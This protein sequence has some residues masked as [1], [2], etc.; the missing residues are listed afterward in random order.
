LKCLSAALL[1]TSAS[2]AAA[3]QG[4]TN[5]LAS[6]TAHPSYSKEDVAFMTGMIAHHA[7][8]LLMAGWA[9]SHGAS[10]Q[11][12]T[13]CQRIIVSQTDE[14]ASMQTWLRDRKLPVPDGKPAAGTMAG[15]EHM[16][17]PG[18]LSAAQLDTLDKARG[19]AWDRYF[20][21]T[22]I[23]HHQGAIFMVDMLKNFSCSS[24]PPLSFSMIAQALGP[25]IWK[26]H[27]E[28]VTG[29][30]IGRIG[31][32]S[33]EQHG[34]DPAV[35]AELAELNRAY[36]ERFGFR[37]VVFVNRRS[38]AEI[39]PVLR[40]RLGRTREQELETGLDELV[41]IAEDRWSSA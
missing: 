22:M 12:Q 18:M 24:G 11:L 1:F 10:A 2:F 27:T 25:W 16:M 26:R 15:M 36:E 5:P 23:Q 20:L 41:A 40:E 21:T 38:R 34:D 31:E 7:Q 37:F 35:L 17:M 9:P 29:L 14:I 32:R 33:S 30:P 3:Q 6:D 13:L 28:R 8:A 39:L 4:A 19:A